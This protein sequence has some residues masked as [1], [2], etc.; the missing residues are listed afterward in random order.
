MKTKR[1]IKVLI[2][3]DS[4]SI[5][6]MLENILSKGK[7][8][9]VVGSA[10]DPVEADEMIKAYKP[11]IVTLDVEMPHMDGVTYL[12]KL[13]TEMKLN[14]MAVVM[15]STLTQKGSNI[16]MKCYE[17]GAIEVVGKPSSKGSSLTQISEEILTKVY[18]AASSLGL[19]TENIR[20]LDEVVETQQ[21]SDIAIELSPN[22]SVDTILPLKKINHSMAD[23]PII[24]IGSSTG[25]PQALSTLFENL[26]STMPPILI[27]QHM[28]PQFTTS[29]AKRLDDLSNV[30]VVEVKDKAELQQGYAYIS[31]GDKHL[32]VI[33]SRDTYYARA[34]DG[35]RINRHIPSVDVLFRSVLNEFGPNA[36]AVMLTGMGDDGTKC[37][38]ELHDAGAFTIAEDAST[39]TVFGMPR[40]AIEIGAVNEVVALPKIA[41]KLK[42]KIEGSKPWHKLTHQHQAF[43]Q[44]F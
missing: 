26:T 41:D 19:E 3:D 4:V 33:K 36:I 15:I 20:S 37:M 10:S 21:G 24:A 40:V 31:A 14:D 28:P 11:D 39:C 6:I 29:L 22:H 35:H 38:K 12:K 1:D 32:T 43:T 44:S 2:I 27:A 5:R 7:N 13:R 34:I 25:G 30:T 9:V 17:L 23:K 8:L 42:Q 16:A 18:A